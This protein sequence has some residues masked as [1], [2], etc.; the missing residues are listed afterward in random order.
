MNILDLLDRNKITA[1][2]DTIAGQPA[3]TFKLTNTPTPA[4]RPTCWKKRATRSC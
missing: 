1:S 2:A 3:F 4:R